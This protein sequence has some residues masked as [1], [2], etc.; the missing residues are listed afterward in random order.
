MT[1]KKSK[2]Q[3][4][5]IIDDV[6]TMGYRDNSPYRNMESIDIYTPNGLIDMSE[7][8]MP[9]LANGRYLPPYSGMHQFEPGVVREKR[10]MQTGGDID[11]EMLYRNKYNTTLNKR[12]T[13]KFNKWVEQESV[14][15]KR[16]ILMDLG[17]YDV[18]GFYKS[19]DYKNRDNDGHGTDTYKK[20]NH[21]TFSN[22]SKYHGADGFYGGEWKPDGAYQPS[23]QT[24]ELYGEDYLRDQFLTEPNRPEHLDLSRFKSGENTPIPFVYKTGG[25]IPIM[26]SGGRAPLKISDPREFKRREQAYNDSLNLF[27]S[28]EKQKEALRSSGYNPLGNTPWSGGIASHPTI[29]PVQEEAW[30]K[31]GITSTWIDVYE[32]PVQPVVY[33]PRP[34]QTPIQLDREEGLLESNPINL[35]DINPIPFESG[36]YFTRKRK[37][38]E[39]DRGKME[40]F[41]KKTG[42]SIG[43]YDDGGEL[44][45]AGSGY[46]VVRSSERKGKTHKVT[47]P[48]GTVKFFGDSKLGQHPKDPAR[49]KAFYARHK[50]N[51]SGNPYFRAFARKTWE[52]GGDVDFAQDG[53]ITLPKDKSQYSSDDS[54][55]HQMAKTFMYEDKRGGAQ[56]NHISNFGYYNSTLPNFVPPTNLQEAVNYAMKEYAPKL[57]PYQTAMEKGEAFDFLYNTGKDPRAYSIQEYYR[58]YDPTKL[59]KEGKWSGRTGSDFDSLYKNTIAKL[60]ENERRVLMNKG[61]DWYYQNINNPSPGVPSPAYK[62]TWYGRIWNTN[63]FLPFNPDNPKFTLKK[64]EEGGELNDWE[65]LDTAQ[66][67]KFL[68]DDDSTLENIVEFVDPTGLLSWD[69]VKRSYQNTGFSP[70]TGL[71]FLGALPL[72][73]KI[74]KSGKVIAGGTD[75]L[76]TLAPIMKNPKAQKVLYDTYRTY[77]NVGGDKL[78]KALGYTTQLL[79]DNT[80]LFNPTYRASSDAAINTINKI[81]KAARLSK[82]KD[83]IPTSEYKPYSDYQQPIVPIDNT[84]VATPIIPIKTEKSYT[85]KAPLPGQ[86]VPTMDFAFGGNLILEKYQDGGSNWEILP[87]AQSGKA[88]ENVIYKIINNPKFEESKKLKKDNLRHTLT[89]QYMAE[90]IKNKFPS[91]MKYTG[92]PQLYG[93][94]GANILGAA[95]EIS[96]LIGGKRPKVYNVLD[97]INE[98]GE[99]L[100]N[101]LVGSVVGAFGNSSEINTEFIKDLSKNNQ[102]PD[103]KATRWEDQYTKQTGGSVWEMIPD[104]EWE[105]LNEKPSYQKGGKVV[106]EIWQDVTGTPWSEAKKLGFTTGIQTDN[107]NLR[108]QLLSNPKRFANIKTD[109][110]V[111]PLPVQKPEML[112]SNT[113]QPLQIVQNPNAQEFKSYQSV[114]SNTFLPDTVYYQTTIK[115]T[116]NNAYERSI[117]VSNPQFMIGLS[118]PNLKDQWVKDKLTGVNT[119]GNVEKLK[120][121]S[122]AGSPNVYRNTGQ[123]CTDVNGDLVPECAAGIQLSLDYN[124]N[125]SGENR[126]KLGIKGD[127]WTM[128]QNVVDAG[129]QRVYGLVDNNV[130]RNMFSNSR[131]VKNYLDSRKKELN[132]KPLEIENNAQNGDLVEMWYEGSP[133]QNKA[134]KEG[135]GTITTHIGIVTEKEG[136][137][138]VTHNIHGK[139]ESNPLNE[140]LKK[141]NVKHGSSIMV[142]GIVR[143]DYLDNENS[144]KTIGIQINPKAKYYSS[145]SE[146]S[147]RTPQETEWKTKTPLNRD[148]QVFTRGLT[149]Y[150]PKVQEDFGL[151]DKEMENLMKLSFGIFGKES[152]F[153]Q[154]KLYKDKEAKRELYETYKNIAPDY[155]PEG[156]ELSKGKGQIKLENFFNTPEKKQLLEKYGINSKNIWD[157]ENTAAALLLTS[158]INYKNFSDFSGANFK[159]MDALTLQNVLSLAHNKGLENVIKNEFTTRD[160]RKIGEKL[161]KLFKGEKDWNEKWD[162]APTTDFETKSKGFGVYSNLHLN[163]DSYANLVADY[164]SSL[165]VD[166]NK[167][168]E[169]SKKSESFTP[170][171]DVL[172]PTIDEMFLNSAGNLVSKATGSVEKTVDKAKR[173][174]ISGSKKAV[175]GSIKAAKKTPFFKEGGSVWEILPNNE[176]EII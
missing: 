161:K 101:N 139:W 119:K 125:I 75:L 18:Q 104:N 13:K 163:P 158:A 29:K 123:S 84:R 52:E 58:K 31:N 85:Q 19:G 166:Y 37:P 97:T 148:S 105:V 44:P 5:E 103:G 48:D 45:E 62:N 2:K 4:W 46:K 108:K 82:A 15:Q 165:N 129:G 60:P 57:I 164:A 110:K 88:V 8:G 173:K 33:E 50:K 142:S 167:I 1:K 126:K 137:K 124:T 150:A 141:K 89:S 7:T 117:D 169:L 73:G 71:E 127:A 24:L 65:I 140:A 70:Q 175:R 145:K 74:G 95:H 152:G 53:L 112:T 63:D 91:F 55:K 35:G 39:A 42:R 133:N 134:L 38:Q 36:S 20:P 61:R 92:A 51:L 157:T 111:E 40:Y 99:D 107:L 102:I 138:Y 106:S 143:P 155:L 168:K 128:G 93:F 30:G 32:K 12:Q 154:S 132:I 87:Q 144:L 114:P 98:T 81:E 59:D 43:L 76:H 28:S 149:Y 6:S 14:A 113:S 3:D 64:E 94:M 23:K 176:W 162:V 121:T 27:L 56:G 26:Q 156:D 90:A 54:L 136:K 86:S 130:D 147:Y 172:P 118:A 10:I 135:K 34:I 116:G 78:D 160:P 17:A 16:D 72:L 100:F 49:K 9:I 115:D 79:V 146:S 151:T 83:F 80:K 68:K 131:D 96:S 21:P 159:N 11:P 77:K 66:N 171:T 69:D 41:D 47:G 67:G 170:R 120:I 174:I 25:Y 22:Q 153:G 109:K 122:A